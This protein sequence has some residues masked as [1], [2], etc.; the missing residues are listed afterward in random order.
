MNDAAVA[1]AALMVIGAVAITFL[2]LRAPAD[3]RRYE[4]TLRALSFTRGVMTDTPDMWTRSER[5]E[6]EPDV[7]IHSFR[8]SRFSSARH[9][10]WRKRTRNI[11]VS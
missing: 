3:D 4:S 10:P 5:I 7:E 1:I 6:Y 9:S 2:V 8:G 11:G